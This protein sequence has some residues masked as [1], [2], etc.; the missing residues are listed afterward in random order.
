MFGLSTVA[1]TVCPKKLASQTQKKK[2]SFSANKQTST[3]V[4]SVF[5]VT[6]RPVRPRMPRPIYL[7]HPV[8]MTDGG[9]RDTYT[10]RN[11]CFFCF[12]RMGV[13]VRMGV[14]FVFSGT[15]P[16]RNRRMRMTDGVVGP[17]IPSGP[18]DG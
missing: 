11:G 13:F 15:K 6:E 7:Y 4:L 8:R 18:D 12:L 9:F 1:E 2:I 14:F 17:P 10:I 5:G 3:A 16:I